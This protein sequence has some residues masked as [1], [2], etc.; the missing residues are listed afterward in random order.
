MSSDVKIVN[1]AVAPLFQPFKLGRFELAHRLVRL[2][3]ERLLCVGP[4]TRARRGVHLASTDRATAH[5]TLLLGTSNP[6]DAPCAQ[7]Y[8]PLTRNRATIDNVPQSELMAEYCKR[9]PPGRGN[10]S[11]GA[12]LV[13][14]QRHPSAVCAVYPPP[15][16]PPLVA[17]HADSQRATPGGL[18]ITEG[19][20]T[21]RRG[22]GYPAA[23]G[24]YTDEQAREEGP[25][26]V[27]C[28]SPSR[29]GRPVCGR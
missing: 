8:P 24:N 27:T 26:P 19:T 2:R 20:Y 25:A 14:I 28:C 12:L 3:F 13:A 18:V 22:I 23:S 16:Q 5:V 9:T 21:A 29:C 10:C 17:C 11:A 15:P 4:S 7:V 1:A 6:S